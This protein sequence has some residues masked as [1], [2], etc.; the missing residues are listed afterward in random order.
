MA[1]NIYGYLRVSTT[2]QEA[3][4]QEYEVLKFAASRKWQI[5]EMVPET[6]SGAKNY[7]ERKL[8]ELLERCPPKSILIVTEISRLGRSLLE[9]MEILNYCLKNEI[10][11]Y[12]CKELFEL[13]DSINSKILAFAFSL[14]AELERQLI[15]QR[16]KE[17]LA[18]KKAEGVVLGRK[19]G[20][21]SKSKLDIH[22][23]T[24]KELL[25]KRVSQ[26]S[27]SKI[28]GCSNTTLNTYIHSNKLMPMKTE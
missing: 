8:G 14:S 12:T 19:K 6:A 18:R 22:L 23:N 11:L 2:S 4:N 5:T 28:I 24:I 9:V 25:N 26:S 21:H 10:H 27:I 20:S 17:A 16:T 13:N 3:Q 7:K 15:S 1:T